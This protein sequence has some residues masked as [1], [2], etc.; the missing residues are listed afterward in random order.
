MKRIITCSDGTWNKPNT[1]EKGKPVRT[2]VQKLF[3]YILSRDDKGMTQI[4]YYDAGIGAA[5]SWITRVFHGA[6]GKGIDENI[7]DMYKFIA[8][9][10]E[11]D[12]DIEDELFMF[13]FSRGAY[14]ARS[15][16]GLIRKCGIVKKNNLNLFEEAYKLYRNKNVAPDHEEVIRFRKANSYEVSR[17]KFI[18]VWDTVGALGIPLNAFQKINEKKYSFYDTTLSSMVEHAYHAVSLDER[19]SNFRPTLWKKSKNAETR[20][21]EQKLEQRW[22]AGVHSNVG[23]GYP[24]EGLADIALK[25]M[26]TKALEADLALDLERIEADVKENVNGTLY[27]SK[28]G[29]FSLLPDYVRP[30]DDGMVD[31]SVHERI[32]RLAGYRPANINL[33]QADERTLA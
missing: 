29:I 6:T 14:T 15:L 24:D 32:Q 5:G 4:K 27:N 30:L 9:N 1:I 7:L 25:W 8:W 20:P 11:H 2:N 13:G 23:G 31:P 12:G 22:F 28:S 33:P 10:F 3:D 18:G 17:I 16:A 19:R 26:I 21:F